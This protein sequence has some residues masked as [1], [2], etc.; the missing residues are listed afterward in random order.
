MILLSFSVNYGIST[1]GVGL[2]VHLGGVIAL[3]I[4]AFRP[5]D[6]LVSLVSELREAHTGPIIVIDDGSGPDFQHVF[7]E[8]RPLGVCVLANAVNLGKGSALKRGIN[9]ALL[10]HPG[11]LGVVTADAD[12]QQ[13]PTD[14]MR[15]SEGLKLNPENLIMGA[16]EFGRSTPMRSLIGNTISRYVY[17]CFLGLKIRDTQTG[18]R[19][20]PRRLC[21]VALSVRSNRY[22]FETETL[23]LAA[24]SG[25]NIQEIPIETIYEDNN[26]SSH[27]NPALDSARIY[28][29]I[30]RY[31]ASSIVTSLVDLMA[32]IS[33]ASAVGS[34]VGANL[35]SRAIAVI[36]QFLLLRSFVFKEKAGIIRFFLFVGYVILTGVASGILQVAL[37]D[38]S[39]IGVLASKIFVETIIFIFNFLFLRDVLFRKARR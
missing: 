16:R 11:L 23:M 32:F 35:L 36:V 10:D 1:F 5:T 22:E 2:G 24:S 21:Q 6:T 7:E 26:A 38:A 28:W 37:S 4:P 33:L 31:S 12:G 27:F 29:V 9:A 3:L 8:I 34:I 15:I 39:G 14:I 30:L 19:G 20:M 13:K 17:R 25:I 18:L